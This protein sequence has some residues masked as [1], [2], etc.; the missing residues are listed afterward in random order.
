VGIDGRL[1]Q[2]E[3]GSRPCVTC[4]ID[5]LAQPVNKVVWE[6]DHD[7]F[8]NENAESSPPCPRCGQR[9]LTVVDFDDVPPARP[10]GEEHMP[11]QV[12]EQ[13]KGA[14]G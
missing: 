4:G 2:L 11:E 9:A 12:N 6:D 3:G 10:C 5:P 13:P 14:N 1:P 7:P 8:P